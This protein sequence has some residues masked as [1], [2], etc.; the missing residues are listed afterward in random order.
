[1]T[2][3]PHQSLNRLILK[4]TPKDGSTIDDTRIYWMLSTG[5]VIFKQITPLLP[6][7]IPGLVPWQHFVGSRGLMSAVGEEN[8]DSM[9]QIALRAQHFAK[10]FFTEALGE[11]FV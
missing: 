6:Y 5:S 10:N 11:S 8:D 3:D 4:P 1:M 9:K 7:G 2:L